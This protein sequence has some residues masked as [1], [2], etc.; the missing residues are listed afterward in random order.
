LSYQISENI[1]HNTAI[2]IDYS[3]QPGAE[4]NQFNV[5]RYPNSENDKTIWKNTDSNQG[6]IP[7]FVMRPILN[8]NGFKYVISKNAMSL[9]PITTTMTY[10]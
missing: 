2:V 4:D 10:S 5:L 6:T 8:I 3:S 7:D 1:T 9:D